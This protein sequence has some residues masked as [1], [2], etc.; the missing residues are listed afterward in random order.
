MNK[1]EFITER[2]RIISEML[3]NPDEY[4]I[5]PTTKCFNDLDE[6]FDKI[7]DESLQLI[8]KQKELIKLLDTEP[9]DYNREIDGKESKLRKEIKNLESQSDTSLS[10]S[11]ESAIPSFWHLPTKVDME[12]IKKSINKVR[13]TNKEIEIEQNK[14]TEEFVKMRDSDLNHQFD[15]RDRDYFQRGYNLGIISQKDYV[16]DNEIEEEEAKTHWNQLPAFCGNCRFYNNISCIL[17]KEVK[18]TTDSC[19]LFEYNKEE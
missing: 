6:L 18:Y 14:I 13:A 16:T 4:G 10:I 12:H 19:S 11:W 5:Y 17:S 8:I 9:D 3:D 1:E 15:Y 2:T 7:S